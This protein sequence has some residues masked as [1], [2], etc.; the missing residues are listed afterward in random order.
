MSS[1]AILAGSV[2]FMVDDAAAKTMLE[3]CATDSE[4]YFDA[5][6]PDKLLAAFSGIAQSL[7]QVRLA[8]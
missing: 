3:T 1:V 7:S 4:H 2:A 5:S 6:D 8:R